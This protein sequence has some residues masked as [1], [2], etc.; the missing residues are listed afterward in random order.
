MRKIERLSKN[1]KLSV[2]SLRTRIC[3]GAMAA[4]MVLGLVYANGRL[5][6]AEAEDITDS[7]F[8]NSQIQD[9][10]SSGDFGQSVTIKVPNGDHT[11]KFSG[12]PEKTTT[13]TEHEETFYRDV[14][15][16]ENIK[17]Y[18]NKPETPETDEVKLKKTTYKYWKKGEGEL[19]GSSEVAVNDTVIEFS[20]SEYKDSEGN[21][22]PNV[23]NNS[24]DE[25]S[26]TAEEQLHQ[27]KIEGYD[28]VAITSS[29]SGG[30]TFTDPDPSTDISG[31]IIYYGTTSYEVKKNEEEYAEASWSGKTLTIPDTPANDGN[32]SVTKK[33]KVSVG[34]SEYILYTNTKTEILNKYIVTECSA[35]PTG[36]NVTSGTRTNGNYSINIS[37]AEPSKEIVVNFKTDK[38]TSNITAQK[39]SES[40]TYTFPSGTE[41]TYTIAGGA[42]NN[43]KESV[44]Y[45]FVVQEDGAETDAQPKNTI[46]LNVSYIDVTP[47]LKDITVGTAQV[48]ANKTFNSEAST[49]YTNDDAIDFKATFTKAEGIENGDT[50]G[51][52]EVV[53]TVDNDDKT[54]LTIGT[55]G[56]SAEGSISLTDEGKKS[57]KLD[58]K[59]TPTELAGS[60]GTTNVINIIKDIKAPTVTAACD[61]EITLST[62]SEDNYTA[63]GLTHQKAYKITITSDDS[64]G[65]VEVS[66]IN[67]VKVTDSNNSDVLLTDEEGKETFTIAADS[68]NMDSETKTYNIK[69]TDKAGNV[70]TKTLILQFVDDKA[71]ITSSITPEKVEGTNVLRWTTKN[72]DESADYSIK[73]I[74]KSQVPI[75]NT[76]VAFTSNPENTTNNT[77]ELKELDSTDT[78][79]DSTYAYNYKYIAEY[80]ASNNTA[81]RYSLTLNVTNT[82]G[83]NTDLTDKILVVDLTKPDVEVSN[84]SG[85]VQKDAKSGEWYN[86]LYLAVK[87]TEQADGAGFASDADFTLVGCTASGAVTRNDEEKTISRLVKVKDSDNQDGTL[88]QISISDIAG[89]EYTTPEATYFV[90]STSPSVTT[91]KIGDWNGKSD[92]NTGIVTDNVNPQINITSTDNVGLQKA[93]LKI[94]GPDSKDESISVGPDSEEKYLTSAALNKALK[95]FL[96]LSDNPK[97]GKYNVTFTAV[98]LAGNDVKVTGDFTIDSTKP[99]IAITDSKD[100]GIVKYYNESTAASFK[101]KVKVT[102]NNI[103]TDDIKVTKNGTEVSGISWTK[104]GSNYTY[105]E[106]PLPDGGYVIKADAKDRSGLTESKTASFIIDTVK[107]VLT[108]YV[109]NDEYSGTDEFYKDAVTPSVSVNDVNADNGGVKVEITKEPSDGSKSTKT[110]E[111]LSISDGKFAAPKANDNAKFTYKFIVTDKAGNTDTKTISFTVDLQKPVNDI[112][113]VSGSAPKKDRFNSTYTPAGAISESFTYGQYFNS[114]VNVKAKVKDN[115][116]KTV[117][118]KDN[119]KTV[120]E[121]SSLEPSVTISSEGRH[122]VTVSSVDESGNSCTEAKSVTFTIDVTAPVIS[123]TLNGSQYS[124]GDG[125]R[126]LNVT[127]QLSAVCSDTNFDENDFT[128]TEL[129]T[130]PGGATSSNTANI[131]N[132]LK[133][134]D[135]E[136]DYQIRYTATDRAGNKSAERTVNFRVDKTAPKLTITGASNGGTSRT[137]TTA[138]F[139]MEEDFYSDVTD[140]TIQIYSKVDGSAER[141]FKE[142]KLNPTSRMSSVSEGL[143]E[144]AEYRMVFKAT[145]R[146][147][148]SSQT[149]STFIVDATAPLITLSGVS[150]YDETDKAV[151]L[152]VQLTEA[153]YTT[154]KFSIKGTR[155]GEDGKSENIDFSKFNIHSSKVSNISQEFKED[156]IYDI[157]ITSEDAAGNSSVEKLHF[158]IDSKAPVLKALPEYDGTLLSSFDWDYTDDDLYTDLTV[159][160]VTVLLDGAEYDGTTELSDGSH[161]I[162]IE[163]EDELGHKVSEEYT[164]VIDTKAPVILVSGVED[165]QLLKDATD[166][167]VSVELDADTL[168][169]VEVNGEKIEIKDGIAT[170]TVNQKGRYNLKA[171]AADEAGNKS[172]IEMN[173]TFGSEFPWW[174]IFVIAGVLIALLI[175]VLVRRRKKW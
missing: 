46:T 167:T 126:Y 41:H 26:L 12:F 140:I 138:T 156:G 34:E 151:V 13:D 132:G 91:I 145:D 76:G 92:K 40:I 73:Y 101:Y 88:V 105:E 148:N 27:V 50:I 98:D 57:Y 149:E 30:L 16:S 122:T 162:R 96:G 159:C 118:I 108:T 158:T 125:V 163:A 104:D 169:S 39:G 56:L 72:L 42:N 100:A 58:Y 19:T 20:K 8:Y 71:V 81:K 107:P 83:A 67:D 109:G 112:A 141:L 139:N 97:E 38:A 59:S 5:N 23:F 25:T 64:N 78:D 171:S 52:A 117:T 55:D 115:N 51:S 174:I 48:M 15:D 49:I 136:A 18:K 161:T 95:D 21:T 35:T 37:G 10:M 77:P 93:V 33:I 66:G 147:G 116:I 36:G 172:S 131:G 103:N 146:C 62:D 123:T 60:T 102:D 70:T 1:R 127:G 79:Y 85:T 4:A 11:L 154:N 61:N 137:R 74:I 87:A 31:G 157:T 75:D 120:Y 128:R 143:T 7:G 166:V 106:G 168:T 84:G 114:S 113:S 45:T 68:S 165:G 153:F 29:N 24:G 2:R 121:G 80:T 124:E 175:F 142:V 94:T 164:F 173:F 3:A 119:G 9:R 134:Y 99:V 22:V 90:D 6:K 135:T 170:F 69:V 82:N 47:S 133:S 53:N 32:Y 111:T 86:S 150:N 63:S 130:P 14:S 155:T 44:S 144:D 110:T 65:T 17:Y 54:T 160:K 43:A 28:P 129:I 152:G 89:N